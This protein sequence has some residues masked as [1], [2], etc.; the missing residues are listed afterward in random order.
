MQESDDL[1]SLNINNSHYTTRLSS[2]FRNRKPYK[3]TDP[4]IIPSFI[5]GTV[6]EILVKK[7]QKVN[8][9]DDLIILDAMKMKNRLKCHRSGRI[10]KIYVKAGDRVSKGTSLIEIE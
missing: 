5:P 1:G 7:G 2:K 9:G 8:E 10:K 6:L 3:P 4:G